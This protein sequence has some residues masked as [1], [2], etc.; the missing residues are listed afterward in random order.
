[1]RAQETVI[2]YH[3][4]AGEVPDRHDFNGF[5]IKFYF[6]SD[7]MQSRTLPIDFDVTCMHGIPMFIEKKTLNE[8]T[9]D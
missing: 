9:A 4:V 2:G 7:H 6:W 5:N 8:M 3:I 1:M